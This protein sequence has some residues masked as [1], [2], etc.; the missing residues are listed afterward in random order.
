MK[1]IKI[2]LSLMLS[3]LAAA[4]SVD[5]TSKL[6]GRWLEATEQHTQLSIAKTGDDYLITITYPKSPRLSPMTVQAKSSQG[7]DHLVVDDSQGTTSF[8]YQAKTDSIILTTPVGTEAYHR[9]PN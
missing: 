1:R 7:G 6:E 2:L 4:C 9:A 8:A 5:N 3:V